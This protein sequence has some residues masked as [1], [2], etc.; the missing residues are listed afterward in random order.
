MLQRII[1][2]F[3]C[4]GATASIKVVGEYFR[5]SEEWQPL[6]GFHPVQTQNASSVSINKAF[7]C[8]NE[9]FVYRNEGC[10]LSLHKKKTN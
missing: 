7:V 10:V 2:R 4:T 6:V 1:N 3:L 9:S 5:Y 8:R